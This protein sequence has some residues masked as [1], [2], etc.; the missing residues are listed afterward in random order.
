MHFV[1]LS[2][3]VEYF[4][5]FVI[6]KIYINSETKSKEFPQKTIRTNLNDYLTNPAY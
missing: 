2:K 5:F 3:I 4:Y 1:Y 6:K